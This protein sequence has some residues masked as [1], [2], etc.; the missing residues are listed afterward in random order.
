M[1]RPLVIYDFASGPFWISLYM[2]KI[3]FS[4]YQ[5]AYQAEIRTPDIYLVAG[6]RV[7]QLSY[8][9]P[10]KLHPIGFVTFHLTTQHP[11]KE[12]FYNFPLISPFYLNNNIFFLESTYPSTTFDRPLHGGGD[13][14]D[15]YGCLSRKGQYT[16]TNFLINVHLQYKSGNLWAGRFRH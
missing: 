7:Q 5:C 15:L 11:Y 1:R 8:S 6:K 16:A 10:I 2:R 9:T 14:C 3:L 13:V 12:L 4:F